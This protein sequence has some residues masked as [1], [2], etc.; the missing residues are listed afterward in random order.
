MSGSG[1]ERGYQSSARAQ[2]DCNS[3][4]ITTNLSTINLT[5][6]LTHSAGDILQVEINAT[7]ALVTVNGN[8]QILGSIV[9]VNTSD[10][11][12]CINDGNNYIAKITAINTPVCTV[13]IRRI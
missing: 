6:L 10:I 7:G 9:H 13:N 1:G 4:T 5:I 8:G 3:G 2:F 11:K 12:Q